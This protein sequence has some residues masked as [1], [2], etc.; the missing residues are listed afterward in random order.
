M[1]LL[2][3]PQLTGEDALFEGRLRFMTDYEGTN[4]RYSLVLGHARHAMLTLKPAALD[5]GWIVVGDAQTLDLVVRNEGTDPVVFVSL[6]QLY[7]PPNQ[8]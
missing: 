7:P 5:F 2:F 4:N 8:T 1:T 3:S 6:S